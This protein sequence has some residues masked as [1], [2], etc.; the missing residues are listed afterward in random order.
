MRAFTS[1]L[2]AVAL[3][4]IVLYLCDI[5]YGIKIK[6]VF[7]YL[8]AAL[9]G[10]LC[11]LVEF[12][13]GFQYT[14]V[15]LFL[16]FVLFS[17]FSCKAKWSSALLSGIF[18]STAL[19]LSQLCSIMIISAVFN[20]RLHQ[21]DSSAFLNVSTTVFS[22]ILFLSA[23]YVILRFTDKSDRYSSVSFALL[24]MPAASLLTTIVITKMYFSYKLNDEIA[25]W[26]SALNLFLLISNIVVFYIH[27]NAV[28]SRRYADQIKNEYQLWKN[29]D[30]Y[31]TKLEEQNK[32]SRVL[33]H[34][35]KKH[36]G[37]IG[38]ISSG[39][40]A[41]YISEISDDYNVSNPIDYC[42]DATLNLIT[43]RFY[44]KCKAN[45]I[46]F[47]VNIREIK[48]DFMTAP[49]ITA[50]FDNLLENAFE[51]AITSDEKQ[52]DFT[53]YLRNQNFIIIRL[54]NSCDIRPTYKNGELLTNKKS[55]FHGIGTK[56]IKRVV[57]KYDGDND[58]KFNEDEG[59]FESV[60]M[61]RTSKE[62]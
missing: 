10:A 24:A 20:I 37:T 59:T 30:E 49:D 29:R 31:Y 53:A 3:S 52:I 27:D 34:D 25:L 8:P 56:S 36:L 14:S 21:L 1:A 43:H 28:K 42:K 55:P 13:F 22:L 2:S 60:I 33:M 39:K 23:V 54:T 15:A 26:V 57:K 5:K 51:S 32:G 40:A 61:L 12:I 17:L 44:E 50:L 19:L 62:V 58:M 7:A 18:V 45:G 6:R 47:D 16:G 41:D 11:F 4:A 38:N 9:T 35:I 48:L 46:R